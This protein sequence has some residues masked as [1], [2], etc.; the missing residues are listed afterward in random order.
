MAAAC[1]GFS[2]FSKKRLVASQLPLGAISGEGAQDAKRASGGENLGE[3]NRE[4]GEKGG[5]ETISDSVLKGSL[6]AS[7]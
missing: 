1:M 7:V 5:F 6:V 2:P 4:S 3:G